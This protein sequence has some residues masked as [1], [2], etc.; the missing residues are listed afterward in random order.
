MADENEDKMAQAAKSVYL[1]KFAEVLSERG[2]DC[3]I[4]DEDRLAKAVQT[5]QKMDEQA[6]KV[7]TKIQPV[8]AS[9][10]DE[11]LDELLADEDD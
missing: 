1:A 8:L 2:Y 7:A 9:L 5:A 10:T 6:Q 11:V 3:V 4:Q